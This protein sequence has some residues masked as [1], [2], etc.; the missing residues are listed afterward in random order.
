MGPKRVDRSSFK[1]GPEG[2][3]LGFASLSKA[4]ARIVVHSIPLGHLDR[5][6]HALHG[7]S[8]TIIKNHRPDQ[9]VPPLTLN[10]AG[11]FTQAWDSKMFTSAWWVYLHQVSK[12]APTG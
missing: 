4:S 2:D 11:C 7:A 3:S 6:I 10:Q 1:G 12:T 5:Y 9:P 8:S